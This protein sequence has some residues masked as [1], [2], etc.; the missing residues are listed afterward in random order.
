MA[1]QKLYSGT[2]HSTRGRLCALFLI[3]AVAVVL[4]LART[5]GRRSTTPGEPS[6]KTSARTD[7]AGSA[8]CASCH[9]EEYRLWA[10]SHHGLAERKLDASQDRA[11]FARSQASGV[12]RDSFVPRERAERYEVLAP[13]LYRTQQVFAVARVIGES[14]LRQFL[15]TFPGGRLQTLEVAYGIGPVAV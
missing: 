11:A 8:T 3:C 15:T 10:K 6:D 12:P 9:D 2:L 1:A 7:Y 5:G 13:G 4:M 14:P